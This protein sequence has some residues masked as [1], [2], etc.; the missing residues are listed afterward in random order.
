VKILHIIDSAGLY[1]A[2]MVVLALA[3]AQR[4]MGWQAVIASIGE[5][6]IPTKAIEIEGRRRQ[7]PVV[8][9][10]MRPGPNPAGVRDILW[11]ARRERVHLLHL[12]GYKGDI[13]FG[14]IPRRVLRMP[15][16]ATVHGWTHT[17]RI[18]RLWAYE[19]LDTLSLRCLDAVVLVTARM[20]RHPRLR[21]LRPSRVHVVP[22]GIPDHV[23]VPA[24]NAENGGIAE[25]CS[26]GPLLGAIGRLSR[27]KGHAHLIDALHMLT[28]DFPGLRLLLIGDG[29]LR[30]D[31]QR[32]TVAFGL[33]DRVLFAGYRDQAWVY[34][35]HMSLFVLPSLTEGLP[36]TLLEAM[37]AGAAIVATEVGGVPAALGEGAAGVIVPPGDPARLA[38]GIR[39]LLENPARACELGAAAHEAFV[40]R[41]SSRRMAEGYA[42]IYRSVGVPCRT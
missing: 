8:P 35:P 24:S 27:E 39:S 40:R 31:L 13:L 15:R 42:N 18:N 41:F 12:H 1:G 25:F 19:M 10:R 33:A 2:E 36:I 29:P 3:E 7:I 5:P 28:G 32:R 37:R 30:E 11:Y 34:L 23:P 9:F 6:G 22:N 17:G 4:Q 38:L 26:R 20:R 16:V 14:F 21:G